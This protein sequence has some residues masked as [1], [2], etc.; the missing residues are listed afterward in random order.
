MTQ[1]TEVTLELHATIDSNGEV[2]AVTFKSDGD[3]VHLTMIIIA[4]MKIKKQFQAVILTAAHGFKKG[5][6]P[7]IDDVNHINQH[8]P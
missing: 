3:P 5:L 8:R 6:Y 1:T 7:D 4:A 2:G